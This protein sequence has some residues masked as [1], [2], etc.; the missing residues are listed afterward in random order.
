M[1][2]H[3]MLACVRHACAVRCA[4]VCVPAPMARA[5]IIHHLSAACAAAP[6]RT[7]SLAET[8]TTPHPCPIRANAVAG[9]GMCPHGKQ[10]D[11][12]ATRIPRNAGGANANTSFGAGC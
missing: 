8:G 1:L 3:G 11:G 6:C 9:L 5:P 10:L 12:E 7:T 2:V 4:V